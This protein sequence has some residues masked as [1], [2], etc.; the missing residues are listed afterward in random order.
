MTRNDDDEPTLGVREPR[1]PKPSSL[2]GGASAEP[3]IDVYVEA[4]EV[5]EGGR[6]VIS[7]LVP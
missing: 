1:R 4:E 3:E 7:V 5:A 2:S 6:I